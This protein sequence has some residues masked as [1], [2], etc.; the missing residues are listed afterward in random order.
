MGAETW[1]LTF[2]EGTPLVTLLRAL[3]VKWQGQN[4]ITEELEERTRRELMMRKHRNEDHNMEEFWR[5]M[6][7]C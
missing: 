1:S 6:S 7:G 4:L 5:T 2:A 3:L